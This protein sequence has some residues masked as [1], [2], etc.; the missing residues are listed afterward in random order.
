MDI[1]ETLGISQ[2]EVSKSLKRLIVCALFSQS[3]NKIIP[4][5]FISYPSLLTSDF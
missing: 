4:S 3:T 1:A 5:L 2:S